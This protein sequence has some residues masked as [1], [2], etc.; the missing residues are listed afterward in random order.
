[1]DG[2]FFSI[3]KAVCKRLQKA[4]TF[5]FHNQKKKKWAMLGPAT[6]WVLFVMVY[7]PHVWFTAEEV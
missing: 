5:C 1:M 3:C 6:T 7:V 4:E 2:C